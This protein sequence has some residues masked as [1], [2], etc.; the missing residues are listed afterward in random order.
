MVL[1][2]R[3]GLGLGLPLHLSAA[4][5]AAQLLLGAIRMC[6][7]GPP[8]PPSAAAPRE[9]NRPI[10]SSPRGAALAQVGHTVHE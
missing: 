3:L 5:A 2:L 8:L 9:A 4:A 7:H 6:V 1:G 10:S